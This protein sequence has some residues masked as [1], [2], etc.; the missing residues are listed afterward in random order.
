MNLMKW[1]S[2][3][4]F[5]VLLIS[6]GVLGGI[7]FSDNPEVNKFKYHIYD[8]FKFYVHKLTDPPNIQWASVSPDEEGLDKLALDQLQLKLAQNDTN[9]FLVV[10][11]DK[12]VYEWYAWDHGVNAKHYLAACAKA[13]TGMTTLLV[14]LTDGYLDLEDT[15]AK[16]VTALSRDPVRSRIK[17]KELAYHEAGIDDVDFYEGQQGSLTG[18][19]KDYYDHDEKR[20]RYAVFNAPIIYTP[21]TREK[22]SGIGYYALAYVIT[23][24]LQ[25]SPRDDIKTLLRERI[26]K[27]LHIPDSAWSISYNKH[28]KTDDMKLYAIGSGASLTARAVARIGQLILDRGQYESKQ[29][30]DPR[31]IDEV[32][33]RTG[34]IA[35]N[36]STNHGWILNIDDKW[37]SLPRDAVVGFGGG[38]QIAL[39][40]PSL[41][42]I[43]IR[44]G[45]A[46]KNTE[47]ISAME[48]LDK[49]VFAPLMK[50]VVGKGSRQ[51]NAA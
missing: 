21:G 10:R 28:V 48:I 11:G 3:Y 22:Y 36:V 23:K 5:F 9:S 16:Y 51:Q 44:H 17:I 35:H 18:W 7:K 29:I 42:L 49:E 34:N 38:D 41:D 32:F 4:K 25:G 30:I 14:A 20:F 50:A 2:R 12:I 15:E 26:M 43:M 19:R 33:N 13:V 31:W 46:L 37:P 47:G 1:L 6:V 24:S 45:S 40:V 8:T 39:L 27:P